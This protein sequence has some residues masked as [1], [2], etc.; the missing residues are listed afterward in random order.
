MNNNQHL[1]K[2]KTQADVQECAF[3]LRNAQAHEQEC[4]FI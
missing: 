2:G 1:F 3:I 4:A